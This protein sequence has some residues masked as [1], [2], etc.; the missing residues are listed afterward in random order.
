MH[1]PSARCHFGAS[2]QLISS[3]ST[4]VID[5]ESAAW[6]CTDLSYLYELLAHVLRVPT[7]SRIHLIGGAP[8]NSVGVQHA[9][10]LGDALL[11]LQ[12]LGQGA[13][14]RL[15]VSIPRSLGCK[16]TQIQALPWGISSP[17]DVWAAA[18]AGA[19]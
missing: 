8:P 16:L 14:T 10:I 2:Y 19:Q 5:A 15:A 6:L 17:V 9:W 18:L 4:G 3:W 1:S 12:V 7:H 13:R 11:A